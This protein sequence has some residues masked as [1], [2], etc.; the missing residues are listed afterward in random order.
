MVKF[1]TFVI[2]ELNTTGLQERENNETKITELSLVAVKRKH[3]LATS[4]G[5]TPRVQHK[6]T[7]CFNPE[8][9]I[10]ATARTLSGL[11]NELL[12]SE[13]TFNMATF[14][15]INTFLNN[16][17]K[18]ICLIAHNGHRFDFPLIKKYLLEL[19]VNF[20]SEL[21]YADSLHGFF[22][23][24]EGFG[25]RRNIIN[26]YDVNRYYEPG[27]FIQSYQLGDV[28]YRTFPRAEDDEEP[29]DYGVDNKC[30]KVLRLFAY[31]ANEMVEW[32]ETHNLLFSEV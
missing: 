29:E 5:A 19:D 32:F 13:S 25:V 22:D 28:Y 7:L 12:E 26:R 14:T 16:L 9:P 31:N 2:V 3:I 11:N 23:I 15:I 17:T 27:D 20:D 6:I 4:R 8:R 10:S 30:F 1:A 18:P 24:M 21:R